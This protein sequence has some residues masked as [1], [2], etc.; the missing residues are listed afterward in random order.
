MAGTLT[1][2]A[3]VPTL[4]AER[5]LTPTEAGWLSAVY[6]LGYAPAARVDA[7]RVCLAGAALA[8]PRSLC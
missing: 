2:P 1:V 4:A 8:A 3:L 5:D 7:R 6:Q